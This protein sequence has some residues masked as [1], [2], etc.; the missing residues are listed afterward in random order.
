M[1]HAENPVVGSLRI[2]L[3]LAKAFRHNKSKLFHVFIGIVTPI[4]APSRILSAKRRDDAIF[5]LKL[6][7]SGCR[8]LEVRKTIGSHLRKR[9]CDAARVTK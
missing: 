9:G 5:R 7:D 6:G 3:T 4:P 1:P 2:K 8:F